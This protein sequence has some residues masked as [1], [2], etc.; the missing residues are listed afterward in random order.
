[1]PTKTTISIISK[2]AQLKKVTDNINY[3]N[4]NISDAVALQL[5]Q[6]INA[7]TDNTY[8]NTERTDKRDL[9]DLIPRTFTTIRYGF[10]NSATIDMPNDFIIN[11]KTTDWV[12]TDG[13]FPCQFRF[14]TNTNA[15]IVPRFTELYSSIGI[16]LY[17]N[18]AQYYYPDANW[19]PDMWI[20]N[21]NTEP[22]ETMQ[23]QI[24]TATLNFPAQGNYDEW[25]Q[26]ITFNVTA[27]EE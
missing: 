27:P 9:E 12:Q 20:I 5:A 23:P 24:I 14:K 6:K 26:T 16:E 3:V 10:G 25:E 2:N 21:F 22:L 15:F 17:Q 13:R 4:P 1:M 8:E 19:S 18:S 11:C 7:L